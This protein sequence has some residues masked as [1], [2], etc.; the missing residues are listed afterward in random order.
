M[1]EYLK[2]VWVGTR[3]SPGTDALGRL[4]S[5]FG[6]AEG[7]YSADPIMLSDALGNRRAEAKY[8]ANKSLRDAERLL[9]Y[10]AA[11]SIQLITYWDKRYPECLRRLPDPAPWLF[12]KGNLPDF[13]AEPTV[14]VVGTRD[15][16]EYGMKM[17]HEIAYDL[18]SAGVVTVSGM[19]LGID[20][21]VAAA[22]LGAN[23]KTVAVLGS[24]IDIV[25]PSAHAYLM[26]EIIS[27]GCV[28][29]E[30]AP[31]TR[32]ER[33]NFPRRNRIISGLSDAVLVTCG[34]LYS[35]ALITARHAEE[36]GKLVYALPGPVDTTDGEG[37]MRLL[38]DGCKAASCA[39]DILSKLEEAYPRYIDVFKLKETPTISL[40]E[41]V[42][43]YRVHCK[44]DER[45]SKA[46]GSHTESPKRKRLGGRAVDSASD[47]VS[48]KA[49][50]TA[51]PLSPIEESLLGAL[52]NGD[53]TVDEI[54]FSDASIGDVCAMLTMLEIYGYIRTLPGGRFRRIR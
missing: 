44:G 35:G 38:R 18:A 31:G 5:A 50:D 9:D 10:C 52:P 46:L 14:A 40:E 2:Q 39:D 37:P 21:I 36:Q 13:D 34:S 29:S 30:F 45:S 43:R 28:I 25:Y 15:P 26:R 32:P 12:V 20:G 17:T 54:N 1:S 22:T 53:F 42:R 7:I 8:L 49:E 19:A 47:E 51:S 3:L 16:S 24:G 41:S 48:G 6:D 27:K 4:I 33:W 11:N 23:G